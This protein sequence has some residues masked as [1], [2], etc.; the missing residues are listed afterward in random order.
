MELSSSAFDEGKTIPRRYGY[1][2]GNASP[3]LSITGVP[4]G[5]ASLL[6]LIHI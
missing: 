1:K 3:P 5:A 4:D 2:H 6:S